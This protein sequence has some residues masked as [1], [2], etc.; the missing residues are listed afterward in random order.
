V[1]DT[2]DAIERADPPTEAAASAPVILRLRD[3]SKRFGDVEVLRSLDLDVRRG[4][5][6]T[7]LGASGSGKSVL[8]K[9]IMRL[10]PL[11]RGEI[12]F[13]GAHVE[14][15]DTDA[16]TAYRRRVGMVFQ[17]G[18]LFDSMTVA[19]NL[20]YGP[21]A[22]GRRVMSHDT[23]RSRVAWALAAVGMSETGDLKPEELSGGM[24]KRVSIARTI[25]LKPEVILYDEPTTGLDPIN[26]G[27]IGKLIVQL[28]K[29][30]GV[31]SVIVTHDLQVA[32]K[33]SDRLALLHD[34]HIAAVGS[35][36]AVR[37]SL[38][39]VVKGFL[40]GLPAPGEVR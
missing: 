35:V 40:G 32:F 16:L 37:A 27:R 19:E 30:L 4:E 10:L 12:V 2:P 31:T 14:R 5:I 7:L 13:D 28:R 39:P 15:M 36:A 34:G 8:L 9:L 33:I 23:V 26:A 22:L 3:V 1:I 18:A 25:A 11:D 6:L 24:R 17:G 21:S 29:Q 38:D 20:A